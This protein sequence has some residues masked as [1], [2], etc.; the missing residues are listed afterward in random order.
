MP[1]TI[2]PQDKQHARDGIQVLEIK[3]D[4][5]R[6]HL[7]VTPDGQVKQNLEDELAGVLQEIG[8]LRLLLAPPIAPEGHRLVSVRQNAICGRCQSTEVAYYRTPQT[9]RWA[10]HEL[11]RHPSP[12]VSGIYLAI[13]QPHV[14]TAAAEQVA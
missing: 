6:Q 3:A 2:T 5:I 8:L 12:S 13:D 1:D 10:L 9:N 7:T 14:C 11:V 4:W